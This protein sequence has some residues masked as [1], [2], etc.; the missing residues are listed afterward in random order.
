[1]KEK[2]EPVVTE[3]DLPKEHIWDLLKLS[4]KHRTKQNA[5]SSP[6]PTYRPHFQLKQT[7]KQQ[8]STANFITLCPHKQRFKL[9][10]IS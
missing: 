10:I 6:S 9:P 4:L 7:Q 3:K 5:L 2:E 8:T 1:M